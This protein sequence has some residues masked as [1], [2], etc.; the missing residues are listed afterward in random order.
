MNDQS[1]HIETGQDDPR[2]LPSAPMSTIESVLQQ[3]LDQLAREAIVKAIRENPSWTI[4]D[5][6]KQFSSGGH[7]KVAGTITVGELLGG[8][9]PAAP[10]RRRGRPRK[11]AAAAAAPSPAKGKRGKKG[12]GKGKGKAA[13]ATEEKAAAPKGRRGKV[14]VRTAEGREA[15]DEA[16]YAALAAAGEQAKAPALLGAV[17]GNEHQ[18]R[19]ALKRLAKAKRVKVGGKARGT[20]YTAL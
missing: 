17:G 14:N 5:L 1:E 18:L 10:A 11:D 15:F 19:T 13:A 12:R 4:A 9:A 8:A 7:A 20:H 16:V 2:P 3:T 6:I